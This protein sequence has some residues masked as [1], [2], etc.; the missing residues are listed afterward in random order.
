M[1]RFVNA[2]PRVLPKMPMFFPEDVGHS[3]DLDL[4]KIVCYAHQ[5]NDAIICRERA[6]CTLR[7]TSLLSRGPLKRKGGGKTSKQNNVEP[8]TS[9][10]L[11]RIIVSVNQLSFNG[12]I[13]DWCQELAQRLEA[14][15]PQSTG[16]LVAKVDNEE[17]SQVPS[18]DLSSLTK[19]PLWSLRGRGNFVR[20]HEEKFGN[21]P[22]DLQ[23][24][25]ACD[26]AGF[27]RN[28]SQGQ[29]VMTIPDLEGDGSTCSCRELTYPRSDERSQPKGFIRGNTKS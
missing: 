13:A 6:S 12:A 29:F 4:K 11:L 8:T 15:A 21:C 23:S 2:T 14:R 27:A 24:R 9:E 25:K 20:Q 26:D 17:A 28:V 19:A 16:T 7:G 5:R 10:S 3:S 1:R 18:K 22:E